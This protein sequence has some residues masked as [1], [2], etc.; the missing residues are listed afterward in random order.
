[1]AI[2]F[3]KIKLSNKLLLGGLLLIILL[4][5][6]LTIALRCYLLS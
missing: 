4:M 5:L 6:G 1:M 2:S 3:K